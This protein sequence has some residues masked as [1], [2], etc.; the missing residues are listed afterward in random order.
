LLPCFSPDDKKPPE[1][2]SVKRQPLYRAQLFT[3]SV[4]L[5]EGSCQVR[6][7]WYA[8]VEPF[9]VGVMSATCHGD[10]GLGAITEYRSPDDCNTPPT[11]PPISD[12]PCHPSRMHSATFFADFA[13]E[14]FINGGLLLIS[15]AVEHPANSATANAPTNNFM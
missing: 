12:V 13:D 9:D 14:S 7:K 1:G 4:T 5:E 3:T 2:G 15:L 8:T 6:K 11:L 10:S